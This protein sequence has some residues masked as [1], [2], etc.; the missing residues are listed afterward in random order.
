MTKLLLGPLLRHVGERDATIWVETDAPSEVE[1]RAGSGHGKERTFSVAG[2]HYAIVVVT[3]LP[4]TAAT[5]YQ[6]LLDGEQVWP[7]AGSPFP[8]C[9]LG[10]I[11]PT[12]PIRLIFGSCR[13][14][15]MRHPRGSTQPAPDVLIAFATRMIEQE[16]AKWP[17]LLILLGDQIYADETSPAMQTF[18]RHRRDIRRPPKAEVADFE[19]YTRLY[20]ESWGE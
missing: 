17:D 7:E 12:R 11:H 20:Y 18:I 16:Q 1:V 19:E 9:P 4:P 3:D 8:P 2:H 10:T 5:P 6:V 15:T 14:V 13:E